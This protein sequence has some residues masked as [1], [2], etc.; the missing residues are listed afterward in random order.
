M[1]SHTS[2]SLSIPRPVC[3]SLSLCMSAQQKQTL[4]VIHVILV[5]VSQG[6]VTLPCSD[7]VYWLAFCAPALYAPLGSFL[8]AVTIR[9]IRALMDCHHWK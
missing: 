7:I 5:A 3:L 1:F 2:V 8:S 9:G 6:L 4:T